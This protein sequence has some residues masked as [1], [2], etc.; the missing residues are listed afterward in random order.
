MHRRLVALGMIASLVLGSGLAVAGPVTDVS[1]DASGGMVAADGHSSLTDAHR[2]NASNGSAA[3]V[4][5]VADTEAGTHY[6]TQ[7]IANGTHVALEYM[8]SV[9]KTR[10]YEQYTVRGDRLVET[11]MEFES[12]GWGLPANANVTEENGTF[13]YD[14]PGA[15]KRLTVAPGTIAGH[16]LHVG[17]ATYDLVALTDGRPVDI[18]LVRQCNATAVHDGAGNG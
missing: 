9:E 5:L 8:H 3:Y 7:P 10:V 18:S 6:L 1:G 12:Y 2:N 13:V 11:R 15:L 14:P 4:L 16:R 17:P